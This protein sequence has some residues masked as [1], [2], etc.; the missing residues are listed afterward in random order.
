MSSLLLFC[1]CEQELLDTE[2][3][4]NLMRRRKEQIRTRNDINNQALPLPEQSSWKY[5][6]HSGNDQSFINILGIDR[7]GFNRLLLRFRRYY[8]HK[9]HLG[10][11]GS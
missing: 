6:Y 2:L 9:F 7:S 1:V 3:L 8:N 4:I 5:L 10:K 11:V